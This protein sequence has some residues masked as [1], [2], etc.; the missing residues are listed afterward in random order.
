[1]V[2]AERC[3]LLDP[4]FLAALNPVIC[5]QGARRAG[6]PSAQC[7]GG[8]VP[9]LGF[10]STDCARCPSRPVAVDGDALHDMG[11][12]ALRPVELLRFC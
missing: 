7:G 12:S 6:G 5:A 4:P 3:D 9:L 2:W 1:M 11:T 10:G 8:A